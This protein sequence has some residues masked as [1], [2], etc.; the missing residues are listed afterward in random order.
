MIWEH[1]FGHRLL[2]FELDTDSMVTLVF[3]RCGVVLASG[4]L[5]DRVYIW[6][7]SRMLE[8]MDTDDLNDCSTPRVFTDPRSILL[9]RYRTKTTSILNLSFTRR[10]LLLAAGAFH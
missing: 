3:S 1:N 6:D 4:T 10:N 9:A 8:E 7:F 2:D 5:D